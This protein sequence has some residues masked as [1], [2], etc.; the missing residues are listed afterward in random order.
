MFG[1]LASTNS[2][3]QEVKINILLLFEA[4]DSLVCSSALLFVLRQPQVTLHR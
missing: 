4:C 3:I 2:K 1:P